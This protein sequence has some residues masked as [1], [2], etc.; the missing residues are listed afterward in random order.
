MRSFELWA[1]LLLAS[2]ASPAPTPAAPPSPAAPAAAAPATPEIEE[3]ARVVAIGD[4]HGDVD[5]SLAVLRLAGLVDGAGKWTGGTTILVQTGDT[6]DRGPD[7]RGVLDLLRR[8]G[9]E[10]EAAGG[11]VVPLLGNHEVMNTRGDWRYVSEGDLASFGGEH[12]RRRALSADGDYGRWLS[13]LDAVAQVGGTVFCHGGVRPEWAEKGLDAIN[14]GVRTSMFAKDDAAVLGPDGPLWYRGYV[15][16]DEP[17]ACPTLGRA[18]EALGAR[19]MVVGHT[20][21]KDGR[22]EVRCGGRLAVIDVGI[23]AHYGNHL[24]AWESVAGDAR[25]I[26]PLG[27]NDLADP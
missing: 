21:R 22:I 14:R 27:T 12:A 10:A 3:P 2:C 6:T 15:Q 17:S 26:T 11:R 5:A 8:L 1:L 24:A 16:D 9:P 4:L 25:E 7:S 19:R 13:T 20:T 23:S 18:L